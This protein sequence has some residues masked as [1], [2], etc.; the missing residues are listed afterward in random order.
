MGVEPTNMKSHLI[1]LVL[2]VGFSILAF[3]PAGII[4]KFLSLRTESRL[5][6]RLSGYLGLVYVVLGLFLVG[7]ADSVVTAKGKDVLYVVKHTCGGVLIG[8]MIAL[9]TKNYE[10]HH[11]K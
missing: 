8:L 10:S 9:M 3:A 1:Q 5:W 6:A 7:Y 4:S 11:K 2:A